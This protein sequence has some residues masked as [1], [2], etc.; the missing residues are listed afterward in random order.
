MQADG[1]ISGS[2]LPLFSLLDSAA[3]SHPRREARGRGADFMAASVGLDK[4]LR[5]S[6]KR[7]GGTPFALFPLDIYALGVCG[8]RSRVAL[9]LQ[10]VSLGST[11]RPPLVIYASFRLPAAFL[12]LSRAA[13]ISV[14]CSQVSY[15]VKLNILKQQ[16]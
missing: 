9:C 5:R 8:L 10:M 14:C 6:A 13:E 15:D 7:G 16:K 11:A 2:A 3:V 12:R 1:W 4:K